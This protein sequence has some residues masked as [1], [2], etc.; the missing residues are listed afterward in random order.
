MNATELCY[1][2]ATDLARLIRQRDV[3]P[4]EVIDAVL[5][6]IERVNPRLNA[7]VTV[8]AEAARDAAR[9]AEAAIARGDDVGPIHGVPVSIKDLVPTKGVRTTR[10]SLLYADWVPDVDA[11]VV[12][13]LRDAGGIILGK[14]NT[15]ELGWKGATDNRVFG[16][17]RNPWNPDRTAGGSSGGAGAAVAAGLGQ[18]GQGSDGGGSIRIP[19][20]FCGIFGIK[21]S[22]GRVAQWPASPAELLSH[23]GPMTR[24]VRDA[25]LMLDVMTGPDD[26]DRWSL[27]ETGENFL[28]ACEGGVRGLRVAWSPDLGYAPVEPEVRAIAERAARAFEAL[29][30]TVEEA[31]PG[32]PD[33]GP[34]FNHLYYSSLRAAAFDAFARTPEKLDPG[35]RAALEEYADSTGVQVVQ[36]LV[37]R[38]QMWEKLRVFQER[39][40]LLLTPTLP[41]TA[42]PHGLDWPPVV[43]G[44]EVRHLGW[45]PFSF[46]FNMMGV[47]AATVPAG[48]TAD[49]LPVGLQI[50]GPRLGD[51]L[52]LRASAAFEEAEPWAH[53]RPP[54]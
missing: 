29:G 15:P 26:R 3:S 38:Q 43:N 48:W 42:F 12:T 6:R 50:V 7:Y 41:V 14:T 10:G 53:H 27:P 9:A 16:P 21:P 11:P 46:P 2:S 25:A 31:N 28:A 54:V 19:S 47:P 5:E 49:G 40:D 33:P 20:A 34:A 4:V 8:T 51:A 45:T 37:T 52:V 44:R 39:Y 1:T 36:S 23:I 17:T 30:C 22:F 18:L 24:T 32:F 13:R 35:L